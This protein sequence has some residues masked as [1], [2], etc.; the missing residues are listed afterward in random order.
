M[1]VFNDGHFYFEPGCRIKMMLSLRRTLVRH[2]LRGGV[3]QLQQ[4]Y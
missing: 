2:S 3:L 1:T 4:R